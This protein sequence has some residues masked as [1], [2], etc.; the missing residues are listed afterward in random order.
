MYSMTYDIMPDELDN[1]MLGILCILASRRAPANISEADRIHNNCSLVVDIRTQMQSY[2]D[3]KLIRL[4][5][6]LTTYDGVKTIPCTTTKNAELE[7]LLMLHNMFDIKKDMHGNYL[8]N[9]CHV[10]WRLIELDKTE[11][12]NIVIKVNNKRKCSTTLSK[13]KIYQ[14]TK[15]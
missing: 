7:V 1:A 2:A 11:I 14:K 6:I 8:L 4:S 10:R 15:K 3:L 5:E 13:K 12:I 9:E